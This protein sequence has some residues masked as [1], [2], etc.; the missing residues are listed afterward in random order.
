MPLFRRIPKDPATEEQI[1][2]VR[3]LVGEF[4]PNPEATG[5]ESDEEWVLWLDVLAYVSKYTDEKDVVNPAG[6]KYLSKQ[7]APKVISDLKSLADHPA[8]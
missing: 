5:M 7:D 4:E 2:S 1:A 6:Y 3:S 8:P